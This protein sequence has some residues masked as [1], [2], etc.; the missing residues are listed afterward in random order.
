MRDALVTTNYLIDAN[1]GGEY[2]YM[3]AKGIKTG[4]TNEAGRCLVT[5]ASADGY[6][7]M[8]ILLHA[9]YEEG[10]T[11]DYA[12]MTDAADLFRWALTSLEMNTVATSSKPLCEVKVNLAWGKNSTLLYPE[13]D[14]SAIVPKDCTDENIIIEQ[15]VPESVDAPLDKG[16]VVGKATIYYKA[17]ANSE[18]QKLAE[19][20][21]VA[22]EKIERSGILYVFNI[23]GTVFQ[24]Y[25]FIVIIALIILVLIIYLIISK[26]HGKR[27]KKKRNVKHYRNL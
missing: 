3:Y 26:I 7:Y 23:I 21:V 24:S 17:D 10:V 22:G 19:V 4:T 8:A 13:T 27:K 18:K 2:Y 12:T 1:R 16:S 11:E 5:T 6:S 25:W 20:N 14:L 9:P 15:D